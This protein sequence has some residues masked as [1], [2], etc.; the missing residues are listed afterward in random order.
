[1]RTLFVV[2]LAA[3]LAWLVAQAWLQ[4]WAMPVQPK[5]GER[6][7][8]TDV[9]GYLFTAP[10]NGDWL[11]YRFSH[12][13][14][15]VLTKSVG[16]GSDGS[17]PATMAYFETKTQ[18][19]SL[20]G[21]PVHSF[22]VAGGSLVAKMY[23][24][25]ADFSDVSRRYSVVAGAVRVGDATFTLDPARQDGAAVL[26]VPLQTL[27]LS[28]ALPL[29]DDRLGTVVDVSP[30]D[31]SVEGRVVHCVHVTVDFPPSQTPGSTSLP[32]ARLDA[33]QSPDVPLGTVA[34]KTTLA[35]DVFDARLVAFGRAS[36]EPVISSDPRGGVHA[37]Y[38]R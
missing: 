12:D 13:G 37:G 26:D 38:Q 10:S 22:A 20:T 6:I 21:S 23:V 32:A 28:G 17:G 15:L 30:E 4:A 2:R 34:W 1:M 36:Y 14:R 29:P 27:L 16:F 33:W 11:S 9:F 35:G 25:A 8:Q 3:A 24:D 18:M 5:I 31:T 19:E 7:T